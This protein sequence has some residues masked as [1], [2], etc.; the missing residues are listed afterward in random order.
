MDKFLA[1]FFPQ[2][3]EKKLTTKDEAIHGGTSWHD[4]S[5]YPNIVLA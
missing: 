4:P 3:L 5:R 1:R 2:V